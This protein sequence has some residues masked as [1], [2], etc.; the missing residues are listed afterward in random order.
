MNRERKRHPEITGVAI[1]AR[2]GRMI[3][4]PAPARHG[5]L[6][7]LAGHVG[8]DGATWRQGFT[9]RKGEFLTRKEAARIAGFP[10]LTEAFSEDFW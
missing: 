10:E 4:L 1:L 5:N 8:I 3:A 9:S 2:D 6:F 7:V